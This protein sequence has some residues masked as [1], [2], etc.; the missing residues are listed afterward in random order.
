MTALTVPYAVRR[1]M[2][3]RAFNDAIMFWIR[4]DIRNVA[5]EV[6]IFFLLCFWDP[7]L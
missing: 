1:N 7:L 2:A 6:E 5:A 3:D 4:V